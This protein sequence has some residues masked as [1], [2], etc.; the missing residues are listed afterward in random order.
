[1]PKND[2]PD[3]VTQSSTINELED[4]AK[5]RPL[6]QAALKRRQQVQAW[7]TAFLAS[8]IMLF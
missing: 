3:S 8:Q 2:S 6:H 7:R 4:A 5:I 1:M